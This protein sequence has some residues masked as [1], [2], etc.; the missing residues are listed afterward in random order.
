MS[1]YNFRTEDREWYNPKEDAKVIG[2]MLDND[3]LG[4]LDCVVVW[5]LCWDGNENL[6]DELFDAFH[7]GQPTDRVLAFLV[8]L[9]QHLE[10][11][12]D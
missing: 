1:E 8:W 4:D 9:K 3:H 5:H 6:Y 2:D 12:A 10:D 11:L 7:S